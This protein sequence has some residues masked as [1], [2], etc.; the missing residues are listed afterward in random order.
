MDSQD[1]LL[2]AGREIRRH[3]E[4]AGLSQEQLAERAGLHRNYIGLMERGQRNAALT[5]LLSIAAA[6]DLSLSEL[7]A[8]LPKSNRS[9][10]GQSKAER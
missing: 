2:A 6:L 7:F 10:D 5:T 3:R 9:G 1:N 8:A 4:A